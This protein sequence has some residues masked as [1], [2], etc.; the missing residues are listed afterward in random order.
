MSS[1]CVARP[2]RSKMRHNTL[3]SSR[4]GVSGAS[5]FVESFTLGTSGCCVRRRVVERGYTGKERSRMI[6]PRRFFWGTTA[7]GDTLRC[8]GR[9][10]CMSL[11]GT[12]WENPALTWYWMSSWNSWRLSLVRALRCG[13][14]RTACSMTVQDQSGPQ[15]TGTPCAAHRFKVGRNEW[16]CR[17]VLGCIKLRYLR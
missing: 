15:S 8:G 6:R 17:S 9:S 5:F 3:P 10:R 11:H 4:T 14:R 13:P 2:I 1:V 7:T 12:T 16:S